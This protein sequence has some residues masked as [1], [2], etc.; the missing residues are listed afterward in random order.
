MKTRTYTLLSIIS[1]L[2]TGQALHAQLPGSVET[3][4]GLTIAA[5]DTT[6]TV[7]ETLYLGPG[8]YQ[9]NG[10]WQIYSKNVWI[11]PAAALVGAGSIRFFNPSAAGGDPGPT[12]VDGNNNSAAINLNLALHNAAGLSLT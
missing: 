4:L 2:T 6:A 1:L 9:I 8:N 5:G 7:S 3:D 11:S 12:L 10:T